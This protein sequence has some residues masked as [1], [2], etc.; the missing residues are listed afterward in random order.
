[1]GLNLALVALLYVL[2]RIPKCKPPDQPCGPY[3]IS[4]AIA[5]LYAC[6]ISLSLQICYKHTETVHA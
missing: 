3:S 4:V 1:M 5:A 2:L 6:V